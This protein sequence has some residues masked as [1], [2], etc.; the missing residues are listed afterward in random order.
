VAMFIFH[1]WETF[2]LYHILVVG[3]TVL[4]DFYFNWVG[5]RNKNTR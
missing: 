1:Y 5:G 2:A 4:R 3:P